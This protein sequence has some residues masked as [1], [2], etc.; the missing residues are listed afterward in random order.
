[1]GGGKQKTT[2]DKR[3][4]CLSPTLRFLLYICSVSFISS[5]PW[6][7]ANRTNKNHNFYFLLMISLDKVIGSFVS[8]I[9]CKGNDMAQT[10]TPPCESTII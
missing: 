3:D 10:A 6:K 7:I 9:R 1:M 8:V 5:L 2:A 4:L